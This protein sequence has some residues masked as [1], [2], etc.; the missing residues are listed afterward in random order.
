MRSISTHTNDGVY[1]GYR[2]LPVFPSAFGHS[3]FSL[4]HKVDMRG[5]PQLERGIFQYT[6]S[7][8]QD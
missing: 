5:Y 4:K 2:L 3:A 8:K 7:M 1:I 6:D